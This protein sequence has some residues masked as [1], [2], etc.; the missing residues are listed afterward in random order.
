MD[1]GNSTAGQAITK[2]TRQ[3]VFDVLRLETGWWWG[4]LG[5][6]EFL[7]R[8]YDLEALP[9]TDRRHSDAE[10]DIIQHRVANFDWPNDWIFSDRRFRLADGP[11]EILLRFLCETIHPVVRR[12]PDDVQRL[13]LAFN[14]HLRRDGWSSTRRA[15]SRDTQ[16]SHG[17]DTSPHP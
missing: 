12:D 10:G 3:N 16:C 1:P 14:T 15:R 13:V 8:L 2:V 6:P 5:E 11:D 7:N 9:S 4:E 17:G